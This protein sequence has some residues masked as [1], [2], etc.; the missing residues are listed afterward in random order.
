MLIKRFKR[1][2]EHPGQQ[3]CFTPIQIVLYGSLAWLSI[4][5][6]GD[7][8]AAESPSDHLTFVSHMAVTRARPAE[9]NGCKTVAGIRDS[10]LRF[11]AHQARHTRVLKRVSVDICV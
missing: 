9:I 3:Q 1:E 6:P 10:V 11:T 7:F 5:S 2:T 4:K 8:V